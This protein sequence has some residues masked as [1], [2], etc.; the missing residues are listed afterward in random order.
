M[1]TEEFFGLDSPCRGDLRIKRKLTKNYIMYLI[2]L[3]NISERKL[4]SYFITR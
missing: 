2:H 4:M 3:C 1:P